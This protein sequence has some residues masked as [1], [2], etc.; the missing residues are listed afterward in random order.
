MWVNGRDPADDGWILVELG[1]WMEGFALT[2]A[3]TALPNIG[4]VVPS[5]MRTAAPRSIALR[6]RK[7]LTGA[8]ST[9][10]AAVLTLADR[11]SGKLFVRFDDAPTRVIRC[12]ASPVTVLPVAPGVQMS[13]ATI[14][15]SVTLT[16][17]DGASY[18]TEPQMRALATTAVE[19]PLGT[20]PSAGIVSWGGAWT[21]T[22]ARTLILRDAGGVAR[23]TM[24]FTAPTGESLGATDFLEIDLARRYA[25]KVTSAGV[26]TAQYDW[27]TSGG[28]L[29]LDPAFQDR[30]NTRYAT[31]EISAGTAQLL[32]RKAWAL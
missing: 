26:R 13:V 21:A 29:V 9:R 12:E 22:T 5:T 18:D 17:H 32:Y 8:I 19:I 4:G 25:T 11:L 31:L 3:T 14:E 6:F 7:Y 20:L 16:A 30:T 2:R 23:T 10:D 1:N 24:T 28:W 27:Y 15:A